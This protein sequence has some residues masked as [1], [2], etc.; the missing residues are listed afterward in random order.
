MS[1]VGALL[2]LEYVCERPLSCA[3]ATNFLV[4]HEQDSAEPMD[5]LG[6]ALAEAL[7]ALA[8][9]PELKRPRPKLK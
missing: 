4:P 3:F 8:I 6:S 5:K 7:T 9:S 2:L 1:N